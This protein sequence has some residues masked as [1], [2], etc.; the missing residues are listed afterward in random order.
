MGPERSAG[1][2]GCQV[3]VPRDLDREWPDEHFGRSPSQAVVEPAGQP[4]RCPQEVVPTPGATPGDAVQSRQVRE[5]GVDWG[6]TGRL[7]T[8]DLN[9]PEKRPG[10]AGVRGGSGLSTR[11]AWFL[12]TV[13]PMDGLGLAVH[14]RVAPGS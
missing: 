8:D 11:G 4:C 3:R 6:G 14:A 7:P 2:C 9:R 13:T 1:R 5:T 10:D 12:P